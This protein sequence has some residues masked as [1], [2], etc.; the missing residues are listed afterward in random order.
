LTLTEERKKRK[1]EVAFEQNI[2]HNTN[3]LL[4]NGGALEGSKLS[5]VYQDLNYFELIASDDK[6]LAHSVADA[7]FY[8]LVEQD[9]VNMIEA[10]ATSAMNT[11]TWYTTKRSIEKLESN[12]CLEIDFEHLYVTIFDRVCLR[13]NIGAPLIVLKGTG[14]G[15]EDDTSVDLMPCKVVKS[16]KVRNEEF[17]KLRTIHRNTT[18]VKNIC[19]IYSTIFIKLFCISIGMQKN[20]CVYRAM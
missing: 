5:Q 14:E 3:K 7:A 17:S 11:L 20:C 9:V 15:E 12:V 1:R 18:L 6:E 2:L 16:S 4:P 13:Y 8:D 19:L 10:G